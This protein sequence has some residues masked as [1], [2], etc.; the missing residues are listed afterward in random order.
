[1]TI[2]K[3]LNGTDLTIAIEGRLDT[4]TAPQ[5]EQELNAS[6]EGVNTLTLDFSDLDYISSAGL[7]VL[8]SAHKTMSKKGGMKVTHVNEMVSDVF[9]VTGFADILN[10]E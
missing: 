9:D 4:T 7:R 3:N 5:L 8:L 10:I 2:N 1:M 6:L